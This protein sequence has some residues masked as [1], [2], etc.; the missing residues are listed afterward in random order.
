MLIVPTTLVP[1][2][3]EAG[4]CINRNGS[5]HSKGVG[6]ETQEVPQLADIREIR[7]QEE[8]RLSYPTVTELGSREMES[9]EIGKVI[10]CG[11]L[12]GECFPQM[13]GIIVIMFG[14]RVAK[15]ALIRPYLGGLRCIL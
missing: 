4:R 8:G 15:W 11:F 10:Y 14:V 3:G 13:G 7:E 5:F 9:M 6:N 1:Q 2:L 12:G